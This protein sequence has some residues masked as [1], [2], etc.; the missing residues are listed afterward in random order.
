[1]AE[2]EK[3]PGV[4]TLENGYLRKVTLPR[5]PRSKS[6]SPVAVAATVLANPPDTCY[7]PDPRIP[8]YN[9]LTGLLLGVGMRFVPVRIVG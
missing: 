8:M 5:V 4:G 3:K 1:M 9:N 2:Q 6:T 7:L